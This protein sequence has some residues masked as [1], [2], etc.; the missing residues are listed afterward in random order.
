MAVPDGQIIGFAGVGPSR[1][2]DAD[3]TTRELRYLYLDPVHCGAGYGHIL[4]T[5]ALDAIGASG[6]DAATLWVLATNERAI[7]FY[8]SHG[9]V[10]EGALKTVMQGEVQLDETRYRVA[11]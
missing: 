4:H 9:W 10:T 11:L 1:D 2:D 8:D 6:A 3:A 7:H 5:A